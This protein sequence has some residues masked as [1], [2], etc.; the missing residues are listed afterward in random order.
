[1]SLTEE[2]SPAVVMDGANVDLIPTDAPEPWSGTVRLVTLTYE[3]G[4]SPSM[5]ASVVTEP[6]SRVAEP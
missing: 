6:E 4:E 1:M 3:T 5:L 2:V